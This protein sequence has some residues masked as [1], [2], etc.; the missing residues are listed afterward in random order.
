MGKGITIL[1]LSARRQM[2][3]RWKALVELETVGQLARSVVLVWSRNGG[4]MSPYLRIPTH[5]GKNSTYRGPPELSDL[6]KVQWN[7]Q[8]SSR[9][10]PLRHSVILWPR[11][12]GTWWAWASGGGPSVRPC[13]SRALGPVKKLRAKKGGRQGKVRHHMRHGHRYRPPSTAFDPPS[14]TLAT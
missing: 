2:R 7:P 3:A 10:L 6:A 9:W 13:W 8:P 11:R 4:T 5:F 12:R 1:V 14:H